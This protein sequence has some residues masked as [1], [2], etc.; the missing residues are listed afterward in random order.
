[1]LLLHPSC[2]Q[3]QRSAL[4]RSCPPHYQGPQ[5]HYWAAH[6]RRRWLLGS[7]QQRAC[8]RRRRSLECSKL[9][10]MLR[11]RPQRM[12]VQE[13]CWVGESAQGGPGARA[14]G[15]RGPQAVRQIAGGSSSAAASGLVQRAAPAGHGMFCRRV[16]DALQAV[17]VREHAQAPAGGQMLV[18]NACALQCVLF[19]YILSTCALQCVL[20]RCVFSAC[21]LQCILFRFV[22]RQSGQ[23][24][25]GPLLKM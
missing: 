6:P 25:S 17:H 19:R 16:E 12:R 8:W 10:L 3:R 14:V 18:F 23:L 22:Q 13:H 20:L 9:V 24:A 2:Q 11:C 21:A 4:R 7:K 15:G 5:L 1:V